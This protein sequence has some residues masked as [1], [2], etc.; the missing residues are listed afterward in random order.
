[1]S[2]P[3]RRQLIGLACSLTGVIAVAGAGGGAA[4]SSLWG[5][6]LLLL[7]AASG[8]SYAILGRRAF[9]GPDPLGILAGSTLCGALFL[10][11]PAIAEAAITGATW[12]SSDGMLL[13]L[14]LGLGCSALA[15]ALWAYGLRHLTAAQ[16]AVFGALELPVGLATAALLLGEVL[17]ATQLAG[18]VLL[19]TG[20]L[21]TVDRGVPAS[22]A[23]GRDSCRERWPVFRGRSC[24]PALQRE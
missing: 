3:T 17:G 5:D 2:A 12:P 14:Y 16:N 8:A 7:A 21:W 18:A 15:F 23:R 13:L 20:A 22:T 24:E 1:M 11:P 9:A 19:L 10:A 4:G 6:G